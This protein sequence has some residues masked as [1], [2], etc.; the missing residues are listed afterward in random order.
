MR[1]VLLSL[2]GFLN[3]SALFAT[4]PRGV[5]V[6]DQLI[7][8]RKDSYIMR[9]LVVDSVG[10]HYQ[11]V[12]KSFL[13]EKSLKDGRVLSIDKIAE[14][15]YEVGADGIDRQVSGRPEDKLEELLHTKPDLFY[16]I[17]YAIPHG[18]PDSPSENYILKN[19]WIV[20]TDQKEGIVRRFSVRSKIPSSVIR[21]EP[22][23]LLQVYWHAGFEL[24]LIA[25][26]KPYSD[27]NYYQKIIVNQ[28]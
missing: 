22:L 20:F 16:D 17:E 15:V 24:F 21:E 25:F 7:G 11:T 1:F 27:T 6:I 12:V 3:A 18:L 13:V 8:F 9:Q 19:G 28:P 26:G 5:W 14:I 23:A 4:P 2:I 10:S